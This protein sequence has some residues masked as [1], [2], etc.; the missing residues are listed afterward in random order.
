M[1]SANHA[2]YAAA[3]LVGEYLGIP[4]A[5]V[6]RRPSVFKPLVAKPM[7]ANCLYSRW[8]AAGESLEGRLLEQRNSGEV[9]QPGGDHAATTTDFRDVGKVEIEL[10]MFG[11][12]QRRGFR[13]GFVML[14]AD[15]GVL[16]NVQAFRVSRHQAIFDSVVD[17]FHEMAGARWAAVQIA[18]LGGAGCFL[19][20]RN[21]WCVAAGRRQRSENWIEMPDGVVFAADHLAIAALEAPDA[22]AGPHINIVNAATGKFLG[23]ANVVD[24][25][26]VAAIDDDVAR[27]ELGRKVVQCGIDNAGGDQPTD[28]DTS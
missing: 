5:C 9:E 15:V 14:L 13:V 22:S 20:A 6:F 19:A 11:I 18:F 8:S 2:Q 4:S 16:E 24:V 26:G 10:I 12:A 28:C 21:A 7:M 1:S 3:F 25:V 17:H 27:F 23:A